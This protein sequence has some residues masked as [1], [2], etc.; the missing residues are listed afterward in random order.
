MK[1]IKFTVVLCL[2]AGTAVG[3]G[4]IQP[5]VVEGLTLL[6]TPATAKSLGFTKCENNYDYYLCSRNKSTKFF[7][8]TPSNVEILINGKDNYLPDQSTSSGPKLSEVSPDKLS[9]RGVRM[10]YDLEERE[11]LTTFLL[12]N[13]WLKSGTL[14]SSEYFK[15]GVNASIKIHK[16]SVTV[17]PQ[18]ESKVEKTVVSL[19]RSS[20]V[21]KTS[22][23]QNNSFIDSMR[24]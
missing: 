21:K 8:T 10:Q 17:E 14:N 1:C 22:E 3:E 19:K 12:G 7:G 18:E 15:S 5:T 16:F 9:Y 13:G 24:E 6:G 23:D 11:K 2:A 20:E 4:V